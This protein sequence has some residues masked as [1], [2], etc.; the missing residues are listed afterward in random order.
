MVQRKDT[1]GVELRVGHMRHVGLMSDPHK[2]HA[3]Q[4]V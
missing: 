4:E 2:S 1:R 3:I